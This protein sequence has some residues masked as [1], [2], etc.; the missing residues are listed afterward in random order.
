MIRLSKVLTVIFPYSSSH[1]MY[2]FPT[3]S[4]IWDLDI[5]VGCKGEIHVIEW[6]VCEYLDS[7]SPERR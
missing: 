4:C 5:I 3:M 1:R 2:C 6:V 7:T